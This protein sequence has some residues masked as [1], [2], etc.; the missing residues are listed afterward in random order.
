MPYDELPRLV[1]GVIGVVVN[2]CQWIGKHGECLLEGDSMPTTV[3][4]GLLRIPL[5]DQASHGG[6]SLTC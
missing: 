3:G 2:R 1:L 6:K 5:E 4:G